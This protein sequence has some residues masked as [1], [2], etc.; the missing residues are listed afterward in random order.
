MMLGGKIVIIYTHE[1]VY[2]AEGYF[3][4]SMRSRR[5]LLCVYVLIEVIG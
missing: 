3:C 4:A 2:A 1:L 5:A